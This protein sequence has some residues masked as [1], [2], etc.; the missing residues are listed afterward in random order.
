M[1]SDLSHL[2]PTS[3]PAPGSEYGGTSR[4]PA[5]V[6][7]G[8]SGR[9]WCRVH[10]CWASNCD[11]YEATWCRWDEDR[12]DSGMTEAEWLASDDPEA[13]LRAVMGGPPGEEG[14]ETGIRFGHGRPSPRKLRLFAVNLWHAWWARVPHALGK[15]EEELP[16][17]LAWC[18]DP[19]LPVPEN[20]R[21]TRYGFALFHESPAGFAGKAVGWYTQAGIRPVRMVTPAGLAGNRRRVPPAEAAA[22]LREVVGDP[23]RPSTFT[24][25]EGPT[26]HATNEQRFAVHSIAKVIYEDRR[27]GEL[28]VLA[29]ALEDACC[30]DAALLAHLRDRSLPHVRGCWALD[31]V[32]GKR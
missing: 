3:G 27:F 17:L 29:D 2:L 31:L 32:L 30:D 19:S 14:S 13:M 18:D 11:P 12:E 22:L 10:Q 24:L 8:A 5:W 15:E 7:D 23:F 21:G 9:P 1:P 6:Q 20:H 16:A 4:G 28:G 26:W 25:F